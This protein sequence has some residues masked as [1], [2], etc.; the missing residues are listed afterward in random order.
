[1]MERGTIHQVEIDGEKCFVFT[2]AS[3]KQVIGREIP[4]ETPEEMA[5]VERILQEERER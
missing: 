4:P 5:E 2:D 3:G 1:M